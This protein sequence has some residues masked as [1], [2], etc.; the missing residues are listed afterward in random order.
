MIDNSSGPFAEAV[1]FSAGVAR[2]PADGATAEAL[3]ERA[4]GRMYEAKRRKKLSL[5]AEEA[6]A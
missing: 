2:Y 1:R 4:D 3:L 6:A 5:V